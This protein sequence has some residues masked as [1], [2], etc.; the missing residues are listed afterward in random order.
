MQEH[1]LGHLQPQHPHR[2]QPQQPLSFRRPHFRLAW[3]LSGVNVHL[4]LGWTQVKHFDLEWQAVTLL[5]EVEEEEAHL[6]QLGV[7]VV[8]EAEGVHHH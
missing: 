4:Y 6:H 7:V 8:V 5:E 1:L 3:V 2:Q